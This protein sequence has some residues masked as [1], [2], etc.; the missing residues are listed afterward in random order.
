[1]VRQRFG[2]K[3]RVETTKRTLTFDLPFGPDEVSDHF[4]RYIGPL[5]VALSRL[6]AAGKEA[7]TK[8]LAAHWV[9]SNQGDAHHTVVSGEYLDVRVR[10]QTR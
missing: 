4:G 8:E 9:A 10:P 6:D 3:V 1:M 7:L 2:P 5:Q